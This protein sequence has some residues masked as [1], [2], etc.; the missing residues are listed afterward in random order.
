MNLVF[1][2]DEG[3]MMMWRNDLLLQSKMKMKSTNSND[4]NSCGLMR[5]RFEIMEEKQKE[6]LQL[7]R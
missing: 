3:S 1:L 4:Q 7:P 2:K 6:I 5:R